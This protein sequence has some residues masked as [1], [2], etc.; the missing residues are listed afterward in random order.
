MAIPVL[1]E[2]RDGKETQRGH[3]FNIKFKLPIV[4]DGI[5]Y[6]DDK[7]KSKGYSIVN[8]KKGSVVDLDVTNKG[9][10]KKNLTNLNVHTVSF[11]GDG[12][13]L[14]VSLLDPFFYYDF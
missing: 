5:E 8:G 11:N 9:R 3:I 6:K 13:V 10:P 7:N 2:T 12:L 1:G 14:Q 4:N